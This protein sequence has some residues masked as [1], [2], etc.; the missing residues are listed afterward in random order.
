MLRRRADKVVF[1]KTVDDIRNAKARGKLGVGF[2]F[3]GTGAFA[4]NP[5]TV[6]VFYDLGIR[7]VI[8]VYNQMNAAATGCHERIDTGLSRYGRRLVEEANRVGMILDCTHVGFKSSMEIIEASAEPVMFSHSNVRSIC[9]H[10]RNINDEQIK[11]CCARGGIIG[12]TGVGKFLSENGTANVADVMR[13]I[14]YLID[15]VGPDH[16][17]LGIDNV[18]FLDQHYRTISAN[19]DRWPN[20]PPPPWYYFAPEDVPALIDALQASDLSDQQVQGIL[21]ENFLRLA[22]RVWR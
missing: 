1:V 6:E 10:Q 9:D 14:R 4:E 7:H 12:V 19:P 13:H 18:Y 21:G 17:A 3:Q 2:H 16:I 15:L 20:Y 5:D 8:L 11:A 22:S